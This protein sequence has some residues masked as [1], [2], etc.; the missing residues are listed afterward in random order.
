MKPQIQKR[1]CKPRRDLASKEAC[2]E[3]YRLVQILGKRCKASGIDASKIP[4]TCKKIIQSHYV[5]AEDGIYIRKYGGK[6]S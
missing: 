5:L 4:I 2:A 3:I 1:K 6:K